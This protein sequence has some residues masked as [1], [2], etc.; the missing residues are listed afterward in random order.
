MA[1]NPFTLPRTRASER[2]SNPNSSVSVAGDRLDV[3][4]DGEPP[5]CG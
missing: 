2:A 3:I 4:V 1:D 5:S